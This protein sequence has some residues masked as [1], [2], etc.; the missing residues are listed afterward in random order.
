MPWQVKK[1][2]RH[3]PNSPLKETET[4][5]DKWEQRMGVEQIEV[6]ALVTL[7]PDTLRKMVVKAIEPFYDDTLDERISE[8]KD[9][10]LA[11]A[12]ATIDDHIDQQALKTVNQR[13]ANL[14]KHVRSEIAKIDKIKILDEEE[15]KLPEIEMPEAEDNADKAPDPLIDSEWNFTSQCKRLI[16]SKR[17]KIAEDSGRKPELKKHCLNCGKEFWTKYPDEKTC[18][19]LCLIRLFHKR[20]QSRSS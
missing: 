3:L 14:D 16:Q 11:D 20:R 18:S 7:Y 4:R 13:L 9:E 1:D 19:S 12:Q 10:W 5:A 15:I 6:D 2:L 17:Y 8:A